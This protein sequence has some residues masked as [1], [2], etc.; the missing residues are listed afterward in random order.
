MN[1]KSE[2]NLFDYYYLICSYI[3]S[4]HLVK[5]TLLEQDPLL[6]T[7]TQPTVVSLQSLYRHEHMH[8]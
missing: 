3:R 1:A 2:H 4:L 5:D 6:L 7:G 8:R